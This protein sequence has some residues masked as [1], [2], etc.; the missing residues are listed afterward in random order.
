MKVKSVMSETPYCC[1]ESDTSRHAAELMRLHDV[2]SIPVVNNYDD[3][4]LVGIV[5][6]RDICIQI[7]ARGKAS[8]SVCVGNVMSE[9]PLTCRPDD[10]IDVCESIMEK[11]QVR[12]V[13]VVDG[14][15]RCVGIVSLADIALEDSSKHA[16]RIIAAISQTQGI[17]SPT[18]LDV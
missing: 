18:V 5:T 9:F 14:D 12:R 8:D 1:Q 4:K 7:A 3:R 13:P 11:Q 16:A 6:D 10:S 17:A 15:G 2:G